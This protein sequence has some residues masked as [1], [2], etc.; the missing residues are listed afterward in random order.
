MR[1]EQAEI[2]TFRHKALAAPSSVKL[3]KQPPLEVKNR[4]SMKTISKIS[5]F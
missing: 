4:P 2:V 1:K 3:R 5:Q